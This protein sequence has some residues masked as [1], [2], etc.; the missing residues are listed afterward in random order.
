MPPRRIGPWQVTK[1]RVVYDNPWIT[2]IDHEVIHPSG[3][4]GQ[5]GKI[6]FKNR[7]IGVLAIREDGAIPIV[8]QHRFPLDAYSWE[9]PEGGG[10]L[11]QS[12]LA[13]AQRELQEETGYTAASWMPLIE[14]DLSN[15][16]SDEAAIGFLAWDLTPGPSDPEPS[17]VLAIRH[18]DFATLTTMC[19]AG[20]V[21]DS[22]TLMMVLAAA[23]RLRR[24][25]LPESLAA[26]LRNAG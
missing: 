24:G 22:L 21:R 11:D 4:D 6:H 5:Y 16:V 12:P 26:A 15:S 19:L 17:E 3:G 2:V 13:A 18:V 20:E 9:L 8:G 25:E 23:E 10:P 7:A 14:A 1:A